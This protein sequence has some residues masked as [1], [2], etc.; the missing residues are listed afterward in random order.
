MRLSNVR[1]TQSGSS[2][3]PRCISSKIA[4]GLNPGAAC[5]IGTTSG[6]KILISG[7]GRRRPRGNALWEELPLD[8]FAVFGCIP[9][10]GVDDCKSQWWVQPLFAPGWQDVNASIPKLQHC[11]TGIS[12]LVPY[13]DAMQ[14]FTVHLLHLVLNR[15]I[16]IASTPIDAGSKDKVRTG[17][18]GST[19][20]LIDIT[21]AIVNVNT[22]CRRT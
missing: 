7:S 19:E 5:N 22:T 15:V 9:L 12:F 11:F 14:P 20:E 16:S 10:V 4:I 21:S 6:S 3:W 17:L 1:R 18:T 2:G 8:G 13:F